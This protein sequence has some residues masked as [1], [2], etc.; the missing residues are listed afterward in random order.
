[1]NSE[2]GMRKSEGNEFGSGNAEIGLR[3]LDIDKGRNHFFYNKQRTTDN[4]QQTTD[5]R[6]RTTDNGQ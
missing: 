6:Q 1:M 4:G 5:N 2:V 3:I